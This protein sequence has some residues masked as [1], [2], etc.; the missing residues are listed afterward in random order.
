[1]FPR[2][3]YLWRARGQMCSRSRRKHLRGDWRLLITSANRFHGRQVGSGGGWRRSNVEFWTR[4]RRCVWART[5]SRWS[6]DSTD[7]RCKTPV[8]S[9]WGIGIKIGC[10]SRRREPIGGRRRRSVVVGSRS[11]RRVAVGSRSRRTIVSTPSWN[12]W[13]RSIGS[14]R[15]CI[16]SSRIRSSWI[17]T[18]SFRKNKIIW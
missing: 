1:M 2:I 13:M 3:R 15:R 8:S 12:C 18:F 4:S 9:A 16:W 7:R 10:G 17:I 11:R 14:R 5:R 6:V